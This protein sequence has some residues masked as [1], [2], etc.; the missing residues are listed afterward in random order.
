[1][2]AEKRSLQASDGKTDAQTRLANA[3]QPSFNCAIRAVKKRPLCELGTGRRRAAERSISETNFL[4][5][6]PL[7]CVSLHVTS[8]AVAEAAA[9][10]AAAPGIGLEQE[11]RSLLR[12]CS[13]RSVPSGR[14]SLDQAPPA[15]GRRRSRPRGTSRIPARVWQGVCVRESPGSAAGRFPALRAMQRRPR[16]SSEWR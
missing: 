15:G 11:P 16:R 10:A 5:F 7:L 6:L 14:R 9:A 13:R 1:M 2:T 4:E 12:S 8:P 3:P